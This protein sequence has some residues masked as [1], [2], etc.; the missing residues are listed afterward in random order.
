[1]SQ[2][3]EPLVLGPIPVLPNNKAG[4][5]GSDCAGS[6]FHR[7]CLEAELEAARNE[8]IQIEFALA[9]PKLKGDELAAFQARRTVSIAR[10]R[11]AQERLAANPAIDRDQLT[12]KTKIIF[13]SW[14]DEALFSD[15]IARDKAYLEARAAA[16]KEAAR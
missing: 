15:A 11:E 8:V 13:I 10:S 7:A 4:A 6:I 3:A 12:R 16:R 2:P 9:Y 14:R 5:S 1:M